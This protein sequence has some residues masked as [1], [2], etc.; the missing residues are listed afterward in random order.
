MTGLT[1]D[2]FIIQPTTNT[3]L[4]VTDAVSLIIHRQGIDRLILLWHAD[5]L[6][7]RVSLRVLRVRAKI[8]GAEKTLCFF[9]K[10]TFLK[11]VES[12]VL[13]LLV[14]VHRYLP[15]LRSGYRSR[16][17]GF[18][19]IEKCYFMVT[20]PQQLQER[21]RYL[22]V[23]VLGHAYL[24]VTCCKMKSFTTVCTRRMT[25][26]RR[27]RRPTCSSCTTFAPLL[28]CVHIPCV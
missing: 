16:L 25:V 5:L 10:T 7:A 27:S 2:H 1:V 11:R 3:P 21:D 23:H 19:V 13:E 15:F 18:T 17:W 26:Q 8:V 24:Q 20:C 12:P 28:D 4:K 22:R 14:M 9:K 6:T